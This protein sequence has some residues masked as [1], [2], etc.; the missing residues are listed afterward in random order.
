MSVSS[1]SSHQYCI[2]EKDPIRAMYRALLCPKY[3][4]KKTLLPYTPPA[5][6]K[7]NT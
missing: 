6:T 7:G 2:S 5:Y 1:L 3:M 4:C